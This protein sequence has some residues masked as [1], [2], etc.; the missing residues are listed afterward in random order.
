MSSSSVFLLA[1]Q[2]GAGGTGGGASTWLGMVPMVAIFAIF[3]F[4]LVV[5]MRKRQKAVQTLVES[6]KKGDRVVTTGGLYGEIAA[7]D[8]TVVVLKVADNVKLRVARS[9]ITGLEGD[10]NTG[11]KS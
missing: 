11:G 3:Y 7:I 8:P 1:F 10:G 9:A 6:L 5:P 4:L 2:G